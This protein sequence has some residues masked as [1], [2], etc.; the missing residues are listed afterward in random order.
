VKIAIIG[1]THFGSSYAIGKL[2]PETQLNTRLLD[3]ANT[4]NNIIDSFIER[5]VKI[6]IL[7]GDIFDTRHPTASQLKI[8]SQCISRA[9]SKGIE[10]IIIVVGNHDQQRHT[11]TTTIDLYQELHLNSVRVYS[12]LG[13][14]QVS[15]DTDLILL[16]YADRKML[17]GKTSDEAINNLKHQLNSVINGLY[18]NKIL[19]GHL[20]LKEDVVNIYPDEFSLSELIVPLD[21][22]NDLD[23]VV[24]GHVHKPGVISDKKP[25]IIYSGSMDKVSFGERDHNKSAIVIDTE[26]MEVEIINT[27]VRNLHSIYLDYSEYP[28]PLKSKIMKKLTADINFFDVKHNIKDSIVKVSLKIK[29]SDLYYVKQNEIKRL[30]QDKG[31]HNCS[32]VHVTVVNSRQLRN[33][34]INEGLESKKAIAAFINNL[35]ETEQDK[36]RLLKCA[37]QIIKDVDGR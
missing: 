10:N 33:S 12:G 26:S 34:K 36:T 14:Y 32:G 13:T 7:T 20:M 30:V 22:F 29:D 28:N 18:G 23:I 31:V 37:N 6:V 4:F 19:I 27:K 5:D 25:I 2:D 8:F 21:V 3:F 11:N 9:T 15:D 35:T 1:D 16:P 17:G 24:M